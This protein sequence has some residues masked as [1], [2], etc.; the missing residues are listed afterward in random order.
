MFVY[1]HII[2]NNN[3]LRHDHW[4]SVF[5]WA[6]FHCS[7]QACTSMKYKKTYFRFTLYAFHIIYI[8][9]PNVSKCNLFD[10]R[11]RKYSNLGV[12]KVNSTNV[13][14]QALWHSNG[15]LEGQ[16]LSS[17]LT[18]NDMSVEIITRNTQPYKQTKMST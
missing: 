12:Y 14:R 18:S 9:A 10:T 7:K 4:Y 16:N 15:L 5:C 11:T 13:Q 1:Q 17:C 3:S 2:H 8:Y 6:C